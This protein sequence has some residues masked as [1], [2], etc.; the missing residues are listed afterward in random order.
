MYYLYIETLNIHDILSF[1]G[2]GAWAM[3]ENL[4][5]KQVWSMEWEIMRLVLDTMNLRGP[6]PE[7]LELSSMRLS[8]GL[9]TA[10]TNLEVFS[11]V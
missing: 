5:E 11:V 7:E 1:K 8:V 10:N 2:N 3:R 4:E 9:W 6:H